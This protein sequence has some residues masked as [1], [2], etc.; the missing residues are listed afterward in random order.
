MN[1]AGV[2]DQRADGVPAARRAPPPARGQPRRPGRG[3]PGVHAE[4]PRGEGPDRQ[5]QLD[6]RPD[7]AADGG[8]VRGLEVRARGCQ[9][10]ASARAAAVGDPRL[11]DRAGRGRHADLGQGARDR[12]RLEAEMGERAQ[13]RYGKLAQT[14]RAET[15]KIPER[16][17]EPDEVAKA[18]EQAL[19]AP[20]PKLRYVV[21][22]DAKMRLRVK[23]L[24][25]DRRFD[26]LI[27]RTLD[28]KLATPAEGLR[29]TARSPRAGRKPRASRGC[30]TRAG[31][32]SS[33]TRRGDGR[34]R[35]WCSPRP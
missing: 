11:D 33:A 10:F 35:S 19:T 2:G 24:V 13:A 4:H 9:R 27:A 21:G 17:C 22:R 26:A 23:A 3:D 12:R 7:G 16:G 30:P 31:A 20:R 14:I 6:R 25:G 5:R 1:N 18:I 34:S 8:P 32:P 29:R 15:E 28:W